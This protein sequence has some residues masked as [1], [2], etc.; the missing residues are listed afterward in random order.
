MTVSAAVEHYRNKQNISIVDLHYSADN[1]T[2]TTA[3]INT[4]C[5][6]ETRAALTATYRHVRNN[7]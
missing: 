4:Q 1:Q 5:V 7:L 6:R 3:R 2:K